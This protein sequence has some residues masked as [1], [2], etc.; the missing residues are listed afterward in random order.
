MTLIA[1][2]MR[3]VTNTSVFPGHAQKTLY[4]HLFQ[5]TYSMLFKFIK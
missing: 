4:S 1:H 3:D 5:A 2:L